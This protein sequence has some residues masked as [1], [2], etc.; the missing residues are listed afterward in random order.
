MSVQNKQKR[1]IFIALFSIFLGLFIIFWLRPKP[2][3][4]VPTYRKLAITD[5]TMVT[6]SRNNLITRAGTT[7]LFSQYCLLNMAAMLGGANA[8]NTQAIRI[9]FANTLSPNPGPAGGNLYDRASNK[10]IV[11]YLNVDNQVILNPAY[12][13]YT[14]F[15][16]SNLCPNSC[17]LYYNK[18]IQNVGVNPVLINFAQCNEYK[19]NLERYVNLPADNVSKV[20]NYRQ[21]LIDNQLYPILKNSRYIKV[22][23]GFN[24]AT[25]SIA[26]FA[27]AYNTAG[28]PDFNIFY[29]I[30]P[31]NLCPNNCD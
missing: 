2:N 1:L 29:E 23:L 30:L 13:N 8:L 20:Y 26:A 19:M 4:L 3:P 31:I 16:V 12:S 27:L 17:D 25:N 6:Q 22:F 24:N 15:P 10:L 9:D 11:K 18:Q 21:F 28:N 14:T 7:N 5:T